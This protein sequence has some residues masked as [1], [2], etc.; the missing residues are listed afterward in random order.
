MKNKRRALPKQPPRKFD[1]I[2]E[3]RESLLKSLSGNA[4]FLATTIAPENQALSFCPP[5]GDRIFGKWKP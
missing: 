1:F 5:L 2:C 4:G 3:F